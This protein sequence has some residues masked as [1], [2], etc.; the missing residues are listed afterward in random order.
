MHRG[1][2]PEDPH[3]FAPEKSAEFLRAIEDYSWLLTRG[4]AKT[5]GL[6]LV[7][8]RFQLTQRQRTA[9]GRCACSDEARQQRQN[10]QVQNFES[11]Q[12]DGLNA[13][14]TIEAALAGGVVL[15]GR[16]G[17]YRDMASFHGNYRMVEEATPA[18]LLI[19]QH[20]QNRPAHW[21]LDQ[22]VSNTGRL[23]NLLRQL[24]AQHNWPWTVQLVPD[25]DPILKTTP[26]TIATS[27]SAI[28]DQTTQ[29]YN[30]ARAIVDQL[31]QTWLH[32]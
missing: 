1:P 24:A 23:A 17:C 29:W 32:P 25:P 30:L 9:L 27:D 13:L 8:D 7:G 11:L 2:H 22:P 3:L 20:L 4:Y 31:P 12:I 6:T 18:I 28:L 19:G 5:A 16:D 14:T 26:Q 15:R 10:K 21:L